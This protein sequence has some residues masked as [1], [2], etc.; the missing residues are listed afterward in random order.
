MTNKLYTYNNLPLL[1]FI[2]IDET[3]DLNLLVESGEVS[4]GEIVER[5]K[6]I[7][8]RFYKEIKGKDPGALFAIV[9]EARGLHRINV[10][11]GCLDLWDYDIE[12]CKETLAQPA[13]GV[14]VSSKKKL[15]S[16]LLNEIAQHELRVKQNG[17][18]DKD[19]DE[20]IKKTNWFDV[21][22]MMRKAEPPIVVDA[23]N[24]TLAGFASLIKMAKN[25]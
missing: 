18:K 16:R 10:I 2:E 23:A 9:Q 25:K 1:T 17:G 13:I 12:W 7:V 15:H 14:K 24:T 5:W 20:E 11:A 21:I 8:D 4:L 6:V 22:A 3:N 19:S